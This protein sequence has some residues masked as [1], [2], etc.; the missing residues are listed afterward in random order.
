[1]LMGLYRGIS[2]GDIFVLGLEV[3][4]QVPWKF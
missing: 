2:K 1:M 3:F 4:F